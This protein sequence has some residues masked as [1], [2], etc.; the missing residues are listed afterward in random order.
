MNARTTKSV[1]M[2]ISLLLTLS[3][4]NCTKSQTNAKHSD[5]AT[6]SRGS[7][8]ISLSFPD[9]KL[10]KAFK[11]I[12]FINEET[13]VRESGEYY[14]RL[15]EE[16]LYTIHIIS[17]GYPTR[18]LENMEYSAN[19]ISISGLPLVR[20]SI[21]IDGYHSGIKRLFGSQMVELVAGLNPVEVQLREIESLDVLVEEESNE[22]EAINDGD[23]DDQNDD[24]SREDGDADNGVAVVGDDENNGEDQTDDVDEDA[25]PSD[26]ENVKVAEERGDILLTL[27]PNFAPWIKRVEF[28]EILQVGLNRLD[29]RATLCDPENNEMSVVVVGENYPSAEFDQITYEEN[30][31]TIRI[32][33]A[34]EAVEVGSESRILRATDSN[35]L[36]TEFEL[37]FTIVGDEEVDGEIL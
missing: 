9:Q 31:M 24:E 6:K 18:T 1:I 26:D 14:Q 30:C 2:I 28:N 25:L 23:D 21:S 27:S 35:G 17:V 7:L 37:N 20:T 16:S 5:L 32:I 12:A 3:L 10:I 34:I 19:P 22:N 8:N 11:K 36:M 33:R 13:G 15:I 4:F 29:L